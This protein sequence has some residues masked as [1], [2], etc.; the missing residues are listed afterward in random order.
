[1]WESAD[2]EIVRELDPSAIGPFENA[3]ATDGILLNH[4]Y[5][6]MRGY[7]ISDAEEIIAEEAQLL[8]DI[9]AISRGDGRSSRRRPDHCAGQRATRHTADSEGGSKHTCFEQAGHGRQ[10]GNSGSAS[11][12]NRKAGRHDQ[13]GL[14]AHPLGSDRVA[15][16]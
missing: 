11:P 13:S 7:S 4:D 8:D 2:V 3:D 5:V 6:D 9:E 15:S 12:R 16:A 10:D 14:V 1:M